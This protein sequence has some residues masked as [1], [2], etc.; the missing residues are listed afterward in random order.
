MSK[1]IKDLILDR[2]EVPA[3]QFCR[4]IN[5]PRTTY[6]NI[7]HDNRDYKRKKGKYTPRLITIKKVC[8]YFNVDFH[9]YI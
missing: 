9:D 4:E 7:I 5:M 2:L 1:S 3:S 6:E 8:K